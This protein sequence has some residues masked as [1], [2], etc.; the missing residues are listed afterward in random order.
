VIIHIL[1][2]SKM[3][4]KSSQKSASCVDRAWLSWWP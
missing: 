3:Y 4:S 1:I 2:Q